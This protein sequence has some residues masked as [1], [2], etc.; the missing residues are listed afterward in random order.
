MFVKFDNP[1]IQPAFIEYYATCWRSK[2]E[3]VV[4]VFSG[5]KV[6]WKKQILG[7]DTNMFRYR[8][9]KE[10]NTWWGLGARRILQENR[11]QENDVTRKERT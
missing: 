10:S 5:L 8:H 2:D 7:S 9:I 1:F 3:G 6:Y 4:L 11:C